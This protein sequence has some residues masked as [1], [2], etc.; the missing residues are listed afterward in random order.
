MLDAISC[1]PNCDGQQ[2]DALQAYTQAELGGCET[3]IFLPKSQQP[4]SWSKFRSPV[5]RLKLALYGHPLAGVFWERHCS[6][7]LALCGWRRIPDW[8]SCFA[9]HELGLVL[10]VYVDDFKMAGNKANMSKGR[11]KKAH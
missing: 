7:K 4:A 2:A 6:A 9:H 10:S 5:C 3:W 1:L 8:E 11:Y